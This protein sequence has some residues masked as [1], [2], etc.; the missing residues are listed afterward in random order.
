MKPN[1]FF[2]ILEITWLTIGIV[3]IGF[4]IYAILKGNQSEAIYFLIFTLVAGLMYAFRKRQRK[5]AQSFGEEEINNK[6]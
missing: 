3:S 4:C 5:R 2:R 1:K 6:K